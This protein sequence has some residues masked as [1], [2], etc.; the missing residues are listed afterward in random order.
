M[1][2]YKSVISVDVEDTINVGYLRYFKEEKEPTIRV[3]ENTERLLRFF[4]KKGITT[5]FF[6]LGEVAKIYPELIKNIADAGHEIGIHG[7][8]H[9]YIN[10]V[11]Q[12]QT[13]KEIKYSK[14]LVEDISGQQVFGYRAPYLSI[15]ENSVWMIEALKKMGFLYDSSIVNNFLSRHFKIV[16]HKSLI[17]IKLNDN[18]D[19]FEVA[20]TSFKFLGKKLTLLSGNYL[21]VLPF[22]IIKCI[23]QLDIGK[24]PVIMY[25]HPYEIDSRLAP[26]P[27]ENKINQSSLKTKFEVKV[28]RFN[29]SK[30]IDRLDC[31]LNKYEFT[32]MVN[33]IKESEL[34][35]KMQ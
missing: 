29:R 14:S 7:Y 6:I 8:K 30:L 11:S 9:R 1:K 2:K 24:H 3:V 35:Q 25:L 33:L 13:I 16:Q 15:N 22:K 5:T 26:E 18:S 10:S 4:S 12:E 28:N 27:L 34:Q 21:R 31:L 23:Y 17:K 19:F 32:T 20:P